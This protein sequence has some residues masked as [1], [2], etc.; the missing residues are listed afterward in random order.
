MKGVLKST[1][2]VLVLAASLFLFALACAESP[3]EPKATNDNSS[4]GQVYE[5][6]KRDSI[7]PGP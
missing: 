4:T 2:S 3:M 5:M 1:G 6:A 7:P